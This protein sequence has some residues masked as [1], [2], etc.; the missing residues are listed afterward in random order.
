MV[1]RETI[2]SATAKG[3]DRREFT[4]RSILLMLSGVTITISGCS[5]DSGSPTQSSSPSPASG[6]KVGVVSANHGH[7]AVIK[8]AELSAGGTVMLDIRGA[9]DHPHVVELSASDVVSIRE[10]R[11]VSKQS[12]T[13]ASHNHSVTSN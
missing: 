11:Q 5:G 10:G 13:E 4:L 1:E 9:A 6:D 2:E 8:A 12:S 7:E 3:L